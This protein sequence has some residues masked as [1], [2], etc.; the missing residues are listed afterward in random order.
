VAKI[1]YGPTIA[2]VRGSIGAL[3]Y[4]RNMADHY[5]ATRSPRAASLTAN[6]TA[7]RATLSAAAQAWRDLNSS[8]RTAWDALA[9]DPPEIDYN[10]WAVQKYLTGFAWFVRVYTRQNSTSETLPTDP[11]A[12]SQPT[13]PT[14]TAATIATY[15]SAD[16]A[17]FIT[18]TTPQPNLITNGGFEAPYTDGIAANWHVSGAAGLT[19]SQETVDVYAGAAAQKGIVIPSAQGAQ[20]HS[21]NISITTHAGYWIS[22]AT[23]VLTGRIA[24]IQV[25]SSGVGFITLCTNIANPEWMLRAIRSTAVAAGTYFMYTA[26]YAAENASFLLDEFKITAPEYFILSAAINPSAGRQT[27]DHSYRLLHA[28]YSTTPTT[29]SIGDALANLFGAYP[30]GWTLFLKLQRQT[31][32]GLRSTPALFTTVTG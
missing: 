11:P 12:D 9:A 18:L 23:K 8:Q 30:A 19:P 20:F 3:S 25:Y 10:P 31:L 4:S 21:A 7:A 28:G 14:I 29:I 24:A 26:N 5:I 2:D 6:A 22:A 17:S 32:S 13:P 1:R 27:P 15:G 16:A